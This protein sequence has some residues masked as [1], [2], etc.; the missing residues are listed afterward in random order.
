MWGGGGA[1]TRNGGR[2]LTSRMFSLR[3]NNA[4]A[5]AGINQPPGRPRPLRRAIGSALRRPS[6]SL[7]ARRCQSLVLP[8]PSLPPPLFLSLP[9]PPSFSKSYQRP[10]GHRVYEADPSL[11]RPGLRGRMS[12]CLE[13]GRCSV[14]P[15]LS[16]RGNSSLSV[17][18]GNWP[19]KKKAHTHI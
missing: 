9:S 15:P 2:T 19:L 5:K 11:A 8:P 1:G 3:L 4:V 17:A 13:G 16:M 6:A 7:V 14:P 10:K 12:Q 18:G